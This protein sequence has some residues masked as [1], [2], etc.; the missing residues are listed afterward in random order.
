MLIRQCE[1][2]IRTFDPARNTCLQTDWSKE[3]IEYI[4]L[5][6]HCQ[7]DESKDPRAAKR[8]GGSSSIQIYQPDPDLP[9]EPRYDT[10]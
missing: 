7:C 3:G 2:G 4:L 9:E 1:E 10:R 5:Q 6:Q 8:V